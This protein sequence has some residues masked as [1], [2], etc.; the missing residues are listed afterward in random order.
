VRTAG[1]AWEH[2][3]E[4]ATTCVRPP[5]DRSALAALLSP[6][7]S[8]APGSSPEALPSIIT[9]E[10]GIPAVRAGC[11]GV[12]SRRLC[13]VA[14]GL[15]CRN[16][17]RRIGPCR[18]RMCCI[19]RNR[20]RGGTGCG[21]HSAGGNHNVDGNRNAG[22]NH[23]CNR[24]SYRNRTTGQRRSSER[25][26]HSWGPRNRSYCCNRNH[27]GTGYGSAGGNRNHDRNRSCC[28]R[29]CRNR[30]NCRIRSHHHTRRQ[31]CW[32]GA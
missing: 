10:G 4:T 32:S 15:T 9:R 8:K 31:A 14:Y 12:C 23:D 22:G 26:P 16:H 2:G 17:S 27:D 29:H 30:R 21:N 24:R 28:C 20:N 11:S 18:N 5:A 19:H 25:E 7:N 6:R 13:E 1:E 3:R